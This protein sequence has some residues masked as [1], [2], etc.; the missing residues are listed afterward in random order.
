MSPSK[1]KN[2]KPL[3]Y[4]LLLVGCKSSGSIIVVICLC[5]KGK[6]QLGVR[7]SKSVSAAG[8]MHETSVRE[9]CVRSNG[10]PWLF[11]CAFLFV[12]ELCVR[13]IGRPW[14]FLCAFFVAVSLWARGWAQA[15]ICVRVH[16]VS[17][18][19]QTVALFVRNFLF[20]RIF[21]P[22]PGPRRTVRSKLWTVASF[23]AWG[24][25]EQQADVAQWAE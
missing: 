8:H 25:V 12:R 13:D 19:L 4:M 24:A 9:L 18:K 7:P 22:C 6:A 11:A 14:F 21:V 1:F 20:R 15:R 16:F 2:C 5:N 3:T 17:G 10:R 23:S